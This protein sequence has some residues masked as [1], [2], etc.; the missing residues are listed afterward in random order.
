MKLMAVLQ[1]D[2]LLE[3]ARY[4]EL[5]AMVRSLN[6]YRRRQ[7]TKRSRAAVTAATEQSGYRRI[8]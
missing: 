7:K 2:L 6:D 1:V 3:E 8:L 5:T 4:F